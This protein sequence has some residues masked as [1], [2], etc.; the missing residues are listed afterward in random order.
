MRVHPQVVG[1]WLHVMV[2]ATWH[3]L[4]TAPS[5]DAAPLTRH[6]RLR[7]TVPMWP[8]ACAIISHVGHVPRC[9]C[10]SCSS[11]ARM[12]PRSRTSRRDTAWQARL[13]RG[14]AD[15]EWQRCCRL[16]LPAALP[17]VAAIRAEFL[18]LLFCK[19]PQA[20]TAQHA[21]RCTTS[22]KREGYSAPE[23]AARVDRRARVRV[24]AQCLWWL[25]GGAAVLQTLTVQKHLLHHPPCIHVRLLLPPQQ[26]YQYASLHAV[27][28]CPM[29]HRR[30]CRTQPHAS[31]HMLLP[32]LVWTPTCTKD[33]N[34]TAGRRHGTSCHASRLCVRANPVR[35]LRADYMG[36]ALSPG[37]PP[38]PCQ[39][40]RAKWVRPE[41]VPSYVTAHVCAWGRATCTA[42]SGGTDSS[43]TNAAFWGCPCE[44]SPAPAGQRLQQRLPFTLLQ[45]DPRGLAHGLCTD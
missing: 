35:C 17:A 44:M 10:S 20:P 11:G 34:A 2:G 21:A 16:R 30:P 41:L 4:P 6:A 29:H 18:Q 33:H 19:W 39:M 40:K 23:Y 14:R 31:S 36:R 1:G 42:R 32:K 22:A 45:S 37:H 9:G 3:R 7:I 24:C 13:L 26:H 43:R 25:S 27:V 5:M 38:Q 8:H 12:L 28:W 15:L